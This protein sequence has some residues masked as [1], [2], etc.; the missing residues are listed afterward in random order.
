[1][2]GVATATTGQTIGVFGAVQSPNGVGVY[3]SG[4]AS[5]VYGVAELFGV[6]GA[7]Y[8]TSGWSG[9]FV[10]T[11][12]NGVYISTPAS[13]TGLNVAGGSKN[14]VVATADGAR[15]L[16]SEESS[17]VWFS[18]YGF[19]ELKDGGVILVITH[20][21]SRVRISCINRA[22]SWVKRCSNPCGLIVTLSKAASWDKS[23]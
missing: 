22:T 1:M 12:G 20:S 6:Y 11:F 14:A 17:Q 23:V 4:G 10:T 16:Y 15:L 8:E 21:T 19:G 2:H 3:G 7:T 9:Y 13:Q 18:D 5:G